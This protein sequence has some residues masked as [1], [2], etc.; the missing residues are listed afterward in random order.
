MQPK[1]QDSGPPAPRLCDLHSENTR[2]HMHMQGTGCQTHC[3]TH[4]LCDLGQV[5]SL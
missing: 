5:T 4:Q 2:E 3:T 1:W